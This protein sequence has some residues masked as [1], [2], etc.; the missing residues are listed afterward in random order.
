MSED[1]SFLRR[2][3]VAPRTR[4]GKRRS[5]A[6][7]RALA[8]IA[9]SLLLLRLLAGSSL[10]RFDIEGNRRARTEEILAALSEWRGE[11]LVTLDLAPLARRLSA[12][13]WI[14]KV[15]LAKR[16]PDGLSVHIV[17]RRAAALLRDGNRLFWLGGDG[18]VIAGYDPRADRSEYVLVTGDRRALAEAV[19]LLDDLAAT[20]PEYFSA[21]S[22]ITV[23][24][25]GGFGM[26]D[27]LFRRPVRVLRRDASEKI[28]A[29]LAARSLI[30]TRRWEA[31]AIDLRFADRIVLVGA[32]G[33]GSS[34]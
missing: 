12:H 19:G 22:E 20:H 33:A 32:Y 34:L 25:G 30:E 6:L 15:T 2:S 1:A 29:L 11:N 17:E 13:P 7:W 5:R 31:R 14:E 18:R 8:A 16:F 9:A 21:L 10:S 26:M 28:R 4:P 3:R 27:S 23:L 24:P